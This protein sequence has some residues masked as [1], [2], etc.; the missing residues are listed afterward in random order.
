VR[1]FEYVRPKS[2]D[3]LLAVVNAHGSAARLLGGGT[4]LLVRLRKG[5]D[6]PKIVIDLK[7]VEALRSDV[8]RI[9]SGLRI[10]ARTVMTDIIEHE[11]VRRHFPALVEAATVVGSIQIRNRATLAGNICNASP[12]ADTA[13]ALLIYDASVNLI[14]PG[15]TRR[16]PLQ[17]FFIG[18]GRTVL[19]HGEIVESIDLPFPAASARAAFERLTRRQGVD[20]AIVS[21]C[22]LVNPPGEVRFAFGAV[23]PCPFLVRE[24][25]SRL[26]GDHVAAADLDAA[27]GRILAAASPISD[28]RASREYRSAMLPVLARRALSA[29]IGGVRL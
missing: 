20:L 12:A 1:P 25:D 8:V 14:G 18:P 15:G 11:D 23:G 21:I 3:E 16:V 28:L 4:D 29:A 26:L 7:K 13:P 10:G 17:E 27:L 5:H 2:L 6:P 9:D 19:A 24:D 22:C